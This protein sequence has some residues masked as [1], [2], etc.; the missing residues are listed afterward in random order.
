MSRSVRSHNF[1]ATIARAPTTRWQRFSSLRR[2]GYN[3]AVHLEWLFKL[4]FL[5][6]FASA[7]AIRVRYQRLAGTYRE[8]IATH[9][10]NH[11][12]HEAKPVLIIRPLLGFP[13][14][15]VVMCWFFAPQ[16]ISWSF[17]ISLYGRGQR[18]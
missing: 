16:W 3:Q 8:G 12:A 15:A 6:L 10:E 2:H 5:L 4:S 17:F 14:Y 18:D 9:T 7:V 1:H 13:W 11:L